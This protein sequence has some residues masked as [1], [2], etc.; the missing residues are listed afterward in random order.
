MRIET[1]ATTR[2]SAAIPRQW[3]AHV[4]VCW[5]PPSSGQK[6]IGLAGA[7]ANIEK[8]FY[9]SPSNSADHGTSTYLRWIVDKSFGFILLRT[10]RPRKTLRPPRKRNE[11]AF[12]G[13][14]PNIERLA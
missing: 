7:R 5:N 12:N 1:L 14:I 6:E 9:H 11:R 10:S 13:V 8:H 4:K 2:L 3:D